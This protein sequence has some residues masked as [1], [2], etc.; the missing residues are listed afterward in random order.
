MPMQVSA[1]QT[2]TSPEERSAR[3]PRNEAGAPE[4][5]TP[6]AVRVHGEYREMPGL[7]LTVLQAARLFS[8][9]TDV[10]DAV[11]RELLRRQSWRALTMVPF[12]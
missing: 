7:R 5:M 11:L 3:A 10:A 1:I 12:P 4:A 2:T 8:V 6:L 9:A